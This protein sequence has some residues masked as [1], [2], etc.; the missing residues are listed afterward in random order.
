MGLRVGARRD[1]LR[2][3]LGVPRVE[4]SNGC[5]GS[6]EPGRTECAWLRRLWRSG[7]ILVRCLAVGSMFNSGSTGLAGQRAKEP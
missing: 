1:L 3:V 4:V 5:P 7:V 6:D 2:R